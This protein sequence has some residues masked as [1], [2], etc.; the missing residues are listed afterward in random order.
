MISDHLVKHFE[1]ARSVEDVPHVLR[2]FHGCIDSLKVGPMWSI[3]T[4]ELAA[5]FY[6]SIAK[7]GSVA[8]YRT[9]SE[10]ATM[11]QAWYDKWK[12]AESICNSVIEL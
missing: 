11:L 3:I 9:S 8:V 5:C 6:V 1:G 10:Q 4:G 2:R 7:K 12:A